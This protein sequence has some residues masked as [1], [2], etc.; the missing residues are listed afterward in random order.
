MHLI[1]YDCVNGLLCECM[2]SNDDVKYSGGI[3]TSRNSWLL[4]MD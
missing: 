4:V 1:L 2:Y 3:C